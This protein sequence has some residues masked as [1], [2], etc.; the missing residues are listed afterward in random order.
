[1]AGGLNDNPIEVS[2]LIPIKPCVFCGLHDF[3]DG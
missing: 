1:M 2:W 3:P